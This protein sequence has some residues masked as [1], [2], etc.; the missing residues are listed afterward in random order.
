MTEFPEPITGKVRVLGE[1]DTTEESPVV[2]GSKGT[3]DQFFLSS[4]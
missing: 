1:W 3:E 4:N 2:A